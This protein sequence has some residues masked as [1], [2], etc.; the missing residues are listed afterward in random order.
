MI[1]QWCHT[2]NPS[3]SRSGLSPQSTWRDASSRATK[4]FYPALSLRDL[5]VPLRQAHRELFPC[6]QGWTGDSI[7]R[8]GNGQ[9]EHAELV[10]SVQ[11]GG[12]PN[13]DIGD[14]AA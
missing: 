7:G 12:E 10:S 13:D 2:T 4:A 5:L 14:R 1:S 6:R 8:S 3:T 9:N 11:L